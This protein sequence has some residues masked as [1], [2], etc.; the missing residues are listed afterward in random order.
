[1]IA[2]LAV[3][4]EIMLADLSLILFMVTAVTLS[5]TEDGA[6]GVAVVAGLKAHWPPSVPATAAAPISILPVRVVVMVMA[7]SL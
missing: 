6:G 2:R 3:G 4:W 7:G 5:Q 1:M